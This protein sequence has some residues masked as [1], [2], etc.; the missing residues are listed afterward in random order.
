MAVGSR[1]GSIEHGF[2]HFH[3]F[4]GLV[5]ATTD[6]VCSRLVEFPDPGNDF[7]R[8]RI[9]RP[10]VVNAFASRQ[11]DGAFESRFGTENF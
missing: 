7:R 4:G 6:S 5:H 8:R 3:S 9:N 1:H 11:G 2:A 10:D